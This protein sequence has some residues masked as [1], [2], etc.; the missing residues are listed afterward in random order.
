M[1]VSEFQRPFL[2]LLS[3]VD[4]ANYFLLPNYAQTGPLCV[5]ICGTRV[6]NGSIKSVFVS[7]KAYTLL[8]NRA[9]FVM[10]FP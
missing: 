10:E 6:A 9:E 1:N 3:D 4:I 5:E 2:S 8:P 7:K